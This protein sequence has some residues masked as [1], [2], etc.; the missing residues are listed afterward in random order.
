MKN[1]L[2]FRLLLSVPIGLSLDTKIVP[3]PGPIKIPGIGT[4]DVNPT[5]EVKAAAPPTTCRR[6]VSSRHASTVMLKQDAPQTKAETGRPR[7]AAT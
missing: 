3:R 4:E 5:T 7:A 2:I 6:G 1:S